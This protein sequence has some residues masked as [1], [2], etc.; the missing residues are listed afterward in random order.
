MK[1]ERRPPYY[2]PHTLLLK[3]LDG[4]II[5][6]ATTDMILRSTDGGLT[7]RKQQVPISGFQTFQR[8]DGSFYLLK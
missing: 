3:L 4:S 8:R 6:S 1:K 5:L 2:F 7:W